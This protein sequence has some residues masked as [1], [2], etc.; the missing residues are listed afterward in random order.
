LFERGR[1]HMKTL[2]YHVVGGFISPVSNEYPKKGLIPAIHRLAMCEAAVTGS[3]WISV[4]TWEAR[5]PGYTP[6]LQVLEYFAQQLG[7]GIKPLLLCGGDL[8]ESFNAPGVWLPEH[9]EEILSKYGLVC[10]ERSSADIKAVIKVNPT[11]EK[12]AE[13]IHIFKDV[14]NEISSTAV[15]DYVSKGW[16]VKYLVPDAVE[17]Y[18]LQHNLYKP[19]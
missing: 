10:L 12:H 9:V 1:D 4:E 18:I 6:T 5:Q 11:L 13:N 8:I 14:A 17:Q 3:N 7:E 15:R 16:S 2:G 19:T